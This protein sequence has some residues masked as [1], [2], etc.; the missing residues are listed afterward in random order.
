MF[1]DL[2]TRPGDA[3]DVICSFMAILEAVKFRMI[4][5]MQNRVFGDIKIMKRL[6]TNESFENFEI[7]IDKIEKT[8]E[9][10]EADKETS[11]NNKSGE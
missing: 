7:T 9:S 11:E 1:S 2:I 10:A 6:D 5:I 4:K 3:M 8:E